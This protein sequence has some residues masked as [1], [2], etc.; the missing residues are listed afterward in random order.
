M[1]SGSD[2]PGEVSTCLLHLQQVKSRPWLACNQ[3]TQFTSPQ[4]H[5]HCTIGQPKFLE[6]FADNFTIEF[7]FYPI[8]DCISIFGSLRLSGL[9]D[10]L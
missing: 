4:V 10:V 5:V 7:F 8:R 9:A 3:F 6:D 1:N 2:D